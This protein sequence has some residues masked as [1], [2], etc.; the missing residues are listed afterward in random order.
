MYIGNVFK[1]QKLQETKLQWSS[2]TGRV[3]QKWNKVLD[4][5]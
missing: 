1:G 2:K 3:E 4:F 5:L